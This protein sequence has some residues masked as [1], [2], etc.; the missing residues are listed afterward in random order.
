MQTI[1][2]PKSISLDQGSVLTIGNFDGVH[3]GHQSLI[4]RILEESQKQKQKSVVVTFWPHP[5]EVVSPE[6][7]HRPLTTRSERL[8]LLAALGVDFVMELAF[9]RELA[10]LTPRDFVKDY[11]LPLNLRHLVTGYDFSLGRG[12]SGHTEELRELGYEFGF[13]VEQMPALKQDGDIL[14]STELRKL[15]AKGEVERASKFLGRPYALTGKV[16]AG[17]GRGKILGFPTANIAPPDLLLPKMG[18]YAALAKILGKTYPA[19]VNL[20]HNPTFGHLPLS[21]EAFLLEGGSDFY[22]EELTLNFLT[23]LRPEE[24]F[25]NALEL[26]KQITADCAQAKKLFYEQKQLRSDG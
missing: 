11:L 18:V 2:D 10:N 20:G 1:H 16:I 7:V 12:R 17:F 13:T 22:G 21:L 8:R 4:S 19:L 23:Y 24:R 6:K 15:I 3:L 26:Q 14:S 5:R 25:A 9:T